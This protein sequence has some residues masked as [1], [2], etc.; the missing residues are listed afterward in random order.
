MDTIKEKL[1]INTASGI[2]K[3]HPD[4]RPVFGEKPNEIII[5]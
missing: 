3:S 2:V 4:K 1:Q 5:E